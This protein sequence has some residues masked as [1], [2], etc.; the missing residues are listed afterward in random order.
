MRRFWYSLLLALVA[1]ALSASDQTQNAIDDIVRRS[2]EIQKQAGSQNPTDPSVKAAQSMRPSPLLKSGDEAR[3]LGREL[4]TRANGDAVPTD[5]DSALPTPTGGAI[6]YVLT[7][8]SIFESTLQ[9]LNADLALFASRYPGVAA[10]AHLNLRGLVPP[11]RAF[12]DTLS[13][14]NPIVFKLRKAPQ[15][16]PSVP[17]EVGL[18]PRPFADFGVADLAPV[19]IIHY[20]NGVIARADGIVTPT[21]LHERVLAGTPKPGRLGPPVQIAEKDLLTDIKERVAQL[22][23]SKMQKGA[24][25]RF[26]QRVSKPSIELPTATASET[27][28]FDFSF[29][30]KEPLKGAKGEVLVAAGSRFNP[31]EMRPFNRHV[32]VFNPESA[33][34]LAAVSAFL[35]DQHVPKFQTKLIATHFALPPSMKVAAGE[36]AQAALE[37]RFGQRVYL[38]DPLFAQRFAL[39]ATPSY[40][41]ADNLRKVMLVSEVKARD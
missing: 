31:L 16:T 1:G 41:R 6:I 36:S 4:L 38:L 40:I 33:S 10:Q 3:L 15:N 32:F 18:D 27:R 25:D 5:L 12:T 9:T 26:W 24:R 2:T 13:R 7:T 29:T 30:T 14:L 22:D 23:V 39:R 37:K 17:L 20:P 8:F 11:D 34:E 21:T 28:E 19:V 35:R